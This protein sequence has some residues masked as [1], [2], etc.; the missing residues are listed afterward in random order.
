MKLENI[1]NASF[2]ELKNEFEGKRLADEQL[3]ELAENENV[4]YELIERGCYECRD[5]TTPAGEKQETF[6]FHYEP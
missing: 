4:W 1:R 5:L 6:E 2:E 3:D